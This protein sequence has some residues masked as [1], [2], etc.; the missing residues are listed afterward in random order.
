[1]VATAERPHTL[2]THARPSRWRR[3]GRTLA[4]ILSVLVI[5]MGLA[6]FSPKVPIDAIQ[7]V[8]ATISLFVPWLS[9]FL[10]PTAVIAHVVAWLAWRA[11]QRGLS[12]TS[13]V[14]GLMSVLM[15]VI[16]WAAGGGRWSEFFTSAPT[17]T[18]TY[19]DGLKVDIYLP[20][21]AAPAKPAL[22]YAHGGAW[23]TGTRKDSAPW[24]AW[25]ASQGVAVFSIDY[26]LTPPPRWQD[27]VGDVKCALGWVRARSGAY[28]VSASNVSVAG[29]SAG[30]HL[31][32][33]AAY[34][35]GDK[36]FPP[37]CDVP[38][39]PVRS[40]MNWFGPTDMTRLVAETGMPTEIRRVV[41]AYRGDQP[42]EVVS[43]MAHVRPGLPP[44]LV[45]QGD[46]DHLIP[47]TQGADLAA[48]LQAAGVAG[49]AVTVPWAEHNFTGHW[50][51]WGAQALR[52]AV[53]DFLG[54]H[55]L[56]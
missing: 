54:E 13:A 31:A 46:R 43:P 2:T 8:I 29:D 5:V 24:F 9:L 3:V 55:A 1:M 16:P 48:K 14:A 35:A 19:A 26:R 32:L 49:R 42:T 45:V 28:G 33:L 38:D 52:P 20:R 21:T 39:A 18:E 11:R 12:A 50:G 25:M 17:A 56:N 40:A 15:V 6:Y 41:D 30:G 23:E 34:T 53:L 10:L 4:W 27:A 37:A 51:S 22:V 47:P 7:Q 44:T 36:R